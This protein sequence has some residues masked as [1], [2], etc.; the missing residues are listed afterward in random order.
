MGKTFEGQ[1]FETI[2]QDWFDNLEEP[3]NVYKFSKKNLLST[4]VLFR[5]KVKAIKYAW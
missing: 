5:K 2:L 1:Y 3:T 4:S